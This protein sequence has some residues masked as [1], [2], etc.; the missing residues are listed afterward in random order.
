MLHRIARRI[1]WSTGSQAPS[2]FHGGLALVFL[3]LK[4][5]TNE[6]VRGLTQK[7]PGR[8]GIVVAMCGLSVSL[9]SPD[10]FTGQ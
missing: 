3:P 5:L 10:A 4:T 9:S 7:E 6:E 1:G 8:P 2:P